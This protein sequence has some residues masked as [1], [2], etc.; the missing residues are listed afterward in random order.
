MSSGF[1]QQ[2]LLQGRIFYVHWGAELFHDSF[3]VSLADCQQP[4]NLSE[5][6]VSG[7]LAPTSLSLCLS[8]L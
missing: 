6:F 1:Q 3:Q 4:P 2:E 5:T 7:S 8:S